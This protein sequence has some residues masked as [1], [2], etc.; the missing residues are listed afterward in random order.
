MHVRRDD[1]DVV[2]SPARGLTGSEGR[3]YTLQAGDY[4]V[5][6]DGGLGYSVTF[7]EQCG[8][9]GTITLALDED[10]ICRITFDD[11][12]PTLT[13]TTRV[14]TTTEAPRRR[15]ALRCMC[16]RVARTWPAVRSLA[17]RTGLPT[18]SRLVRT[19]SSDAV[20]GYAAVIS[21]NCAT[22]GSVTLDLGQNRDCT[23]TADDAAPQVQTRSS[24]AAGAAAGAGRSSCRRRWRA[25]RSTR[26]GAAR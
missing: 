18:R 9:T 17:P 22:D 12:A 25:R 24:I 16:G 7:S 23:V 19:V 11:R 3:L 6:A 13:V 2:G 1:V 8:A 15:T 20:A 4:A 5:S 21:G 26:S 10:A 14:I